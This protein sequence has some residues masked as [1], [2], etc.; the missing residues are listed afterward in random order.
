MCFT[1]L[2]VLILNVFHIVTGFIVVVHTVSMVIAPFLC[3]VNCTPIA[4]NNCDI[5]NTNGFALTVRTIVSVMSGSRAT[6]DGGSST[7]YVSRDIYISAVEPIFTN[8]SS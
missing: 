4:D 6:I 3:Y 1:I 7:R 5:I 2:L 8:C